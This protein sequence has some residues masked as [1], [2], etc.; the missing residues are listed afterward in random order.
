M[1]L[2]YPGMKE[3][4]QIPYSARPIV[5]NVIIKSEGG[6]IPASEYSVEVTD[7]VEPGSEAKVKITFKNISYCAPEESITIE[8][9]SFT[10]VPVDVSDI[11]MNMASSVFAANKLDIEKQLDKDFYSIIQSIVIGDVVDSRETENDLRS[12][13]AED[14]P[15][16]FDENPNSKGSHKLVVRMNP[17][18]VVGEKIIL[19]YKV[20]AVGNNVITNSEGNKNFKTVVKTTRSNLKDYMGGYRDINGD[21]QAINYRVKSVIGK[22]KRSDIKWQDGEFVEESLP[23]DF[24]GKITIEVSTADRSYKIVKKKIRITV[25]P[26]E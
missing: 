1:T 10:I 25:I 13:V 6:V 3:N 16:E 2:D 22:A 15:Y 14:V 19:S 8:G 21:K 7:N 12:I 24:T 17:N 18:Y 26:E 9:P 4:N 5:P 11:K 23:Q 20:D